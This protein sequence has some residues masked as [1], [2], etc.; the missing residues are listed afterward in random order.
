MTD[1][2]ALSD[3]PGLLPVVEKVISHGRN[4]L[5]ASFHDVD[6]LAVAGALAALERFAPLHRGARETARAHLDLRR[7]CL[8]AWLEL[9]GDTAGQP[10]S[11]PIEDLVDA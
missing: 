7:V 9:M 5:L 10:A 11:K 3:R 6:G 1:A 4:E 2:A 8:P